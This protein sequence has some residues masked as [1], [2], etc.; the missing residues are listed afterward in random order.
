MHTRR[1]QHKIRFSHSLFAWIF[2]MQLRGRETGRG[3]EHH[4]AARERRRQI[5]RWTEERARIRWAMMGTRETER[6]TGRLGVRTSRRKEEK[7]WESLEPRCGTKDE[8]LKISAQKSPR[9]GATGLMAVRHV[10][11]FGETISAA[12]S[13]RRFV[14]SSAAEPEIE[15]A[16]TFNRFSI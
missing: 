15:A 9:H 7:E 5:D 2:A 14:F 3:E 4:A 13:P 6:T 12:R 10:K 11:S 16:S 8:T 1:M